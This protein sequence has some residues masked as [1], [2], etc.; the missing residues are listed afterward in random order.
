M[1]IPKR[2]GA[3]QLSRCPFCEKQAISKSKQGIPVCTKHKDKNLPEMK[4][5]CGSY[6]DLRDGKFGAYFA[7]IKCGNKNFNR[8]LESNREAFEQKPQFDTS[9]ERSDFSSVKRPPKDIVIDTNDV[10]WF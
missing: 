8:V 3:T 6:L 2:Y 4:C 9:Q 7:C 1:Y 5:D 10:E